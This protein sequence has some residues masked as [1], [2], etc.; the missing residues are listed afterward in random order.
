MNNTTRSVTV[1]ARACVWGGV[2]PREGREKNGMVCMCVNVCVCVRVRARVCVCVM[3]IHVC[4]H[5]HT[6]VRRF[7]HICVLAHT[8]RMHVQVRLSVCLRGRISVF[9]SA[10]HIMSI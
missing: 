1:C 5:T 10:Y 4:V 9:V 3:F 7:V 6:Y 8:T 2:Q